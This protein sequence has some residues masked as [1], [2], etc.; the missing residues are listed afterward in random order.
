MDHPLSI[1]ALT[2]FDELFP[3]VSLNRTSTA[4]VPKETNQTVPLCQRLREFRERERLS[5]ETLS[6][7]IDTPAH[8]IRRWEAGASKPSRVAADRLGSVGFGR[9]DDEETNLRSRSR[10]KLSGSGKGVTREFCWHISQLPD[11]KPPSW[12]LNGPADQ[13]EFYE[14]LMALQLSGK[15]TLNPANLSLVDEFEPG[16]RTFQ[17]ILESPKPTAAS[18]NS[19]YGSHGWHRYVGRFPPHVVR[20]L[21]NHFGANSSSL[22]C[23]PFS[24]SGT[25]AVE[26]RLMGI[27]FIGIEISALS[28]LIA[29][30]KAC[31]DVNFR[32]LLELA[33]KY[34]LFFDEA[35]TKFRA[36]HGSNYSVEDVLSRPG[37]PIPT[38]TNIE[39][40]FTPEA[41]LGVSLTVEFSRR[42][43]GY[44]GDILLVALSAKMRSIG[45]VDVDVVR[46]E[47]SRKPRENVDVARLV[48]RHL[49]KMS[50][51]I[52]RMVHS[53]SYIG[54]EQ[55]IHLIE[56]SALSV[57]LPEQSVDYVITS[58]PYGVEA[59]SYL[60][61]HLL[62]YRSLASELDHDPY[63]T[64]DETIGSEYL[65]ESALPPVLD[66]ERNSATFR[67]FF[68]HCE[69]DLDKRTRQRRAGM[70]TFFEDMHFIGRNMASYL[71]D[72]GKVA[73]II[74][75]K[76]LGDRVI[77]TDQIIAES[78]ESSGLRLYDRL[79]HKLK[80]NNS[81]SQ[82]PW[83]ERI[84]QE[85]A[86][87]LFE[88]VPRE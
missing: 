15:S 9:I 58:P 4:A 48:V 6:E 16:K 41:F 80:T 87:L 86:I 78:F 31:F 3:E 85:E 17:S 18:W 79:S 51:D 72:G 20:A 54:T 67:Q 29:S 13:D 57:T 37:N 42:Y 55:S 74:G 63:E 40:W 27:P 19:N 75:N 5:I 22:V 43:P 36:D 60:R 56:D 23:D 7:R 47:Y 8:L 33:D 59:L 65:E 70:M 46:A 83:Q 26:C 1:R 64:R 62:S 38:F 66:V 71:K 49:R 68:D 28:H 11:C 21:L 34:Q 35:I 2:H 24:G 52:E 77:P 44:M 32:K 81:N 88:R 69:A 45:N 12:M 39:K 73:F 14:R 50:S 30:V 25:T 76:K 84:I 82:V 53:H 10:I 61:T